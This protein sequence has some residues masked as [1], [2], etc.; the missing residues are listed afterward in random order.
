MTT[1][2]PIDLES[3][4]ECVALIDL[5]N[6]RISWDREYTAAFQYTDL[7]LLCSLVEQLMSTRISH[8]V[9][10]ATDPVAYR[11][12]LIKLQIS[13]H[14]TTRPSEIT[15]LQADNYWL[16]ILPQE[17]AAT[18]GDPMAPAQILSREIASFNFLINALRSDMQ[19]CSESANK[20]SKHIIA[21]N[22]RQRLLEAAQQVLA[23]GEVE[24]L[25]DD[26]DD[27]D[28]E[29]DERPA[30]ER[31]ASHELQNLDG[32]E[33]DA[34]DDDLQVIHVKQHQDEDCQIVQPPKVSEPSHTHYP[35]QSKPNPMEA[36]QHSGD[37]TVETTQ[38]NGECSR[39]NGATD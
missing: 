7:C 15:D 33:I 39:E 23:S 27:D 17:L 14:H 29:E 35:T 3:E 36:S 12:H 20:R 4:R 25:T 30:D 26:D 21:R 28:D 32:N 2:A 11:R 38:S 24:A 10:F 8:I 5:E 37:Y 9:V 34:S 13:K 1:I 22:R 16:S 6:I 18:N 31:P 19:H